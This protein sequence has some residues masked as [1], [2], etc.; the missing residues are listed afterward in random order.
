M[1]NPIGALGWVVVGYAL[2]AL[3]V[4][5]LYDTA[6][7]KHKLYDR[8]GSGRKVAYWAG[9]ASGL[10]IGIVFVIVAVVAVFFLGVAA[11]EGERSR[12]RSV[13]R[14]GVLDAIWSDRGHY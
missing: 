10:S 3:S 13:V 9:A 6:G 11:A 14:D 1:I 8:V 12:D 7:F 5:A 2:A 4:W